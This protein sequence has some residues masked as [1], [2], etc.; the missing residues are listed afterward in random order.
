SHMTPALFLT[1]CRLHHIIDSSLLYKKSLS[2]V[3]ILI[4][5]ELVLKSSLK[6]LL[7]SPKLLYHRNNKSIHLIFLVANYIFSH[8]V[9]YHTGIHALALL[10]NEL[11]IFLVLRSL[12]KIMA[13]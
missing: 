13:R 4:F 11:H 7:L 6:F 9:S 12:N 5:Y 1:D 3:V 10:R 8:L 2:L